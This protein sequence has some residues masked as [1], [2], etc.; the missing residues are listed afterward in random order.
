[1]TWNTHVHCIAWSLLCAWH[2]LATI[3][4]LPF[5]CTS[6]VQGGYHHDE[7]GVNRNPAC[8]IFRRL[9]EKD[10]YLQTRHDTTAVLPMEV[11]TRYDP[12]YQRCQHHPRRDLHAPTTLSCA[13]ILDEPSSSLTSQRQR[14]KGK[15][16]VSIVSHRRRKHARGE[17]TPHVTSHQHIPAHYDRHKS[18][19]DHHFPTK[20]M[21]AHLP[22]SD[23]GKQLY[24]LHATCA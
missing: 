19:I 10:L 21:S 16:R 1:M 2:T 7:G 15:D 20:Y 3:A 4:I 5:L 24:F 12:S 23:F 18:P 13:G 14:C 11:N 22:R 9:M 8:L 6:N 17:K